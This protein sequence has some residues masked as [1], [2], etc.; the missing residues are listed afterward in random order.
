MSHS[1]SSSETTNSSSLKAGDTLG[2]GGLATSTESNNNNNNNGNGNGTAAISNSTSTTAR[3]NT[4]STATATTKLPFSI[5]L[6]QECSATKKGVLWE[7]QQNRFFFNRWKE[8][9]FIL[10]TDYLTCFKK[11]GSKKQI[12]G[13]SEM[14]SFVYKINLNEVKALTWVDKKKNGV[15]GVQLATTA[16]F[17]WNDS[18]RLLDDWMVS[19]QESTSRT[20]VRREALRKSATLLTTPCSL[21]LSSSPS[22][23]LLTSKDINL[24]ERYMRCF[25]TDIA[26]LG[27]HNSS[28]SSNNRR[29]MTSSPRERGERGGGSRL[30]HQ[31]QQQQPS[32]PTPPPVPPH[33]STTFNNHKRTIIM[34]GGNGVISNGG[35]D[36]IS[37]T[38]SSRMPLP[39]I[40][41]QSLRCKSS[42]ALQLSPLMI[43]NVGTA[44]KTRISNGFNTN[45]PTLFAQHQQRQRAAAA[46][47]LST[48]SGG[49]G[50]LHYATNGGSY[51]HPQRPQ[52]QTVFS[53]LAAASSGDRADADFTFIPSKPAPA[54]SSVASSV[55]SN[56]FESTV[57]RHTASACSN[58]NNGSS[59]NAHL[60]P[61][62]GPHRNMLTSSASL[63]LNSRRRAQYQQQ[64]QHHRRMAGRQKRWS[65]RRRWPRRRRCPRTE[66]ICTTFNSSFCLWYNTSPPQP[67]TAS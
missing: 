12:V 6:V 16:L 31:T 19:L 41:S 15:I 63:V 20:K 67:S 5:S 42:Y 3:T 45:S 39:P 2:G 55:S 14:G 56:H 1:L 37:S 52:S 48:I 28:S 50:H 54:S 57:P 34:N 40:A 7:Q 35:H 46:K 13:M 62:Q 38:I 65:G 58:N 32:Q 59:K 11:K 33:H 49:G 9:F 21:L 27:D 51:Y 47:R 29:L 66:R 36:Q 24:I 17:L 43:S 4:T 64:Q 22:R 8:R 53:A 26:T 60:L 30:G 10:T 23:G 61:Q 25:S 18:E 44:L